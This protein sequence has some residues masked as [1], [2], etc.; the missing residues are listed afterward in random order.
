MSGVS[1]VPVRT[2]AELDRFIRLPQRLY[3][4]DPCFVAPLHLERSQALSPRKNPY[5]QHAEAQFFLAQRA[6]RDVG[7]ISAQ[8]DRLAPDTEGHFG[9]VA[10]E[11][12][13][14][15]FSGLF[16]AAEAWLCARGRRRALG[17]FNLSIN[18]ESGLLVDGFGTPPMMMMAHD[19]PYAAQRLEACGYVKAK[20]TIAYLYDIE[21]DLPPAARRLIDTR[22]PATLE[23][24]GL[25][26]A[27]YMQEFDLVTNIFNVAWSANWGFIPFTEA[28]IRHM[29]KELKPLIAPSCVAIAQM[30]GNPVGFG[31]LLPNLNEAITG[32]E[33]RLL[34]FNWLRLL[35]RLKRGTR[36]ARVPLMGIRP[37]YQ[38][39]VLGGLIAFLIIDRL[40]NGARARGV[41]QVELSWILEDNWPMRRVIE[42]LGATAYKTYRL[43]EKALA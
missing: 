18:E 25:D 33:G 12:D 1:V 42:S 40:R 28:E 35:L 5:F 43:Y 32:F 20:D 36:S 15:I 14:G 29:A 9:L 30:H 10:A 24:R 7:R 21:H 37:E 19:P 13:A 39:G 6:G 23:V 34:P 3:A 31:V 8:V 22:T 26:A 11:D 27:R 2:R 16:A 41:K 17:P 4:N 38:G